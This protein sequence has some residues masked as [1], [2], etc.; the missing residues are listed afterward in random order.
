MAR[1]ATLRQ[2]IRK[3]LCHLSST[4]VGNALFQPIL[5]C[6]HRHIAALLGI[7]I[8]V[9]ITGGGA[10]AQQVERWTCD[11]QVVVSNPTRGK[12]CVTTMGK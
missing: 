11:Q 10:V 1:C 7:I 2:Y 3:Q 5:Q 6:V 8:N 12:N 4:P 9:V